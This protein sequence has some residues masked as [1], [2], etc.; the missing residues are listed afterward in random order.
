MDFDY[1]IQLCAR[2][3]RGHRQEIE[4]TEWLN[5]EINRLIEYS[6][7]DLNPFRA[8]PQK[9]WRDIVANTNESEFGALLGDI[10]NNFRDAITSVGEC[11][12]SVDYNHDGMVHSGSNGVYELCGIYVLDGSDYCEGP[13]ENKY[14]LLEYLDVD[15][16]DHDVFWSEYA[17]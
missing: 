17:D 8:A 7:L 12:A 15:N 1:Y 13:T 11:I 9:A 16:P 10:E 5:S 2:N 6:S 3:S 4:F 14:E